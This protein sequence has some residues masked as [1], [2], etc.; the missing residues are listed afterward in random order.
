MRAA[1]C[2]QSRQSEMCYRIIQRRLCREYT[3]V[4]PFPC[5]RC[6]FKKICE[7]VFPIG[8]E[9][10]R[11]P[12]VAFSA[13]KA[14]LYSLA[15][16]MAVRSRWIGIRVVPSG[17]WSGYGTVSNPLLVAVNALCLELQERLKAGCRELSNCCH[18][19]GILYSTRPVTGA[20]SVTRASSIP[21]K[22]R[23]RRRRRENQLNTM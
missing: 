12:G 21:G 18:M 10:S 19:G 4:T 9:W 1:C 7:S 15:Y 8:G 3:C 16:S 14:T 5:I 13:M 23:L 20:G 11:G 17:C 2:V 6:K 22:M